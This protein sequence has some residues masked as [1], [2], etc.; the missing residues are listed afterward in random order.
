MNPLLFLLKRLVEQGCP[1]VLS[2]KFF[3]AFIAIHTIWISVLLKFQLVCGLS[4]QRRGELFHGWIEVR[5]EG[6]MWSFLPG[7]LHLLYFLA[8]SPL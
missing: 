5:I 7:P 8:T 2:L 3:T 6:I 4:R 1:M